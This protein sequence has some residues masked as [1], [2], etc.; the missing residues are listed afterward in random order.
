MQSNQEKPSLSILEGAS[1]GLALQT[2]SQ[3]LPLVFVRC[4]ND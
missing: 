1:V 4:G 2:L 3:G